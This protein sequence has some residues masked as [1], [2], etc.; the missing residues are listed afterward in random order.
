MHMGA[1]DAPYTLEKRQ[2]GGLLH[3]KLAGVVKKLVGV[4][5][6][7]T[8]V[9]LMRKWGYEMV[10]WNL[11]KPLKLKWPADVIVVGETL[12]HLTNFD[13]I[14]G[15]LKSVMGRDTRLIISVPNAYSGL[16][17]A[18]NLAGRESINPDHKSTFSMGALKQLVAAE[19]LRIEECWF[20]NLNKGEGSDRWYLKITRLVGQF[21]PQVSETLMVVCRKN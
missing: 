9:E 3:D 18:V 1:A 17:F 2:S 14:F 13:A 21:I 20:T 19:G 8:G 16:Y 5:A 15:F 12:E 10:E 6:D 11:N 7:R 4:D